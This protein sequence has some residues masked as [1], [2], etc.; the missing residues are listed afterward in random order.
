MTAL[1]SLSSLL[2]HWAERERDLMAELKAWAASEQ[3][4]DDPA[5]IKKALDAL[6]VS[7]RDFIPYRDT[8]AYAR[9]A[10]K[11]LKLLEQALRQGPAQELDAAEHELRCLYRVAEHAD[12]SGGSIGDVMNDCI[13]VV[14][15][16]L[17]QQPPKPAWAERFIGLHNDDPFGLWDVNAVLD[18]AGPEVTHHY[19]KVLAKRWASIEA[20][21]GKGDA[22]KAVSWGSDGAKTEADYE[23]DRIR[24]L[25]IADLGRQG[26]PAAVI[27]FMKRSA[28]S[29]HDL[30]DTIV[31]C[32]KHGHEREALALAEAA[33]KRDPKSRMIEDAMLRCC[34]AGSATAGK[35]LPSQCANDVTGTSQPWTRITRRCGP[36]RPPVSRS[37]LCGPRWRRC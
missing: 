27:D 14:M 29:D 36:R 3:A 5:L 11:S 9:R 15:R 25:L 7:T 17:S 4:G 33:H 13:D 8:F 23:R 19:S 22:K 6:L 2:W 1:S 32:E 34:V 30:V 37:M 35:T 18:A 16:A 20:G 31:Y 24:C 26:D 12:D 21:R 28:R 10:A